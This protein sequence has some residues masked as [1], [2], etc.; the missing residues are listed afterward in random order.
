MDHKVGDLVV[1]FS[2]V[3]KRRDID[4]SKATDADF[5]KFYT[6]GIIVEVY[7]ISPYEKYY[8]LFEKSFSDGCSYSIQWAD[9]ESPIEKYSSLHIQQFKK[10]LQQIEQE[11]N[12][13]E[14]NK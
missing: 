2:I 10:Q 11:M 5:Y 13:N 14:T 12:R 8:N 3:P 4:P 1:D 6:Y 7:Q 9:Y